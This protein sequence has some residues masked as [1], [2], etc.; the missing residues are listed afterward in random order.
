MRTNIIK[1]TDCTL[2][3]QTVE[4]RPPAFVHA[5]ALTL[6]LLVAAAISW[7]AL[8]RANLVVRAP[9]R[10]R[11]TTPPIRLF[12]PGTG[13]FDLRVATVHVAEGSRVTAGQV[14]LKFDTESLA[15]EIA[16]QDRTIQT[17]RDELEQMSQLRERLAQQFQAARAKAALELSQARAEAERSRLVQQGEIR[18]AQAELALAQDKWN[19]NEQLVEQR[20]ATEAA[21]IELQAKLRVAEDKLALAQVPLVDT[22]C[23]VLERSLELVDRDFQVR[24][25]ELDERRAA[26]QGEVDAAAK[27]L[28]NLEVQRR[29][30]T[31][32]SPC[33]GVV[34]KGQHHLGDL[35]EPGK[36]VFEVA[37]DESLCFEAYISTED[38]G[39]LAPEMAGRIKFDAFDFQRY[40]T[41]SAQVAYIAPDSSVPTDAA[42][43]SAV[44][45]VRMSVD[46]RRL[47]RGDAC[48]D[49]KLGMA[50]QAE[51]VTERCSI[52]SILLHHVRSAMSLA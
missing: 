39:R 24:L 50:G 2:L 11:P 46:G 8:T 18:Q 48:G 16:R 12:A 28:E 6:S 10:V 51:I 49:I 33:D 5:T 45:L 22:N 44:Y 21:R 30:S 43:R 9:G 7:A 37:S 47:H 31:L 17:G 20:V 41:L 36:A 26:K 40:G 32:T 29:Q 27:Q 34:I 23:E 3:R 25:V 15:N 13:N 42:Q 19:R 14:L 35:L 52:L 1:V 4:S 38:V